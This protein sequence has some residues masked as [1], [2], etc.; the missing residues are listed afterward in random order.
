MKAWFSAGAITLLTFAPSVLSAWYPRSD[1]IIGPDFY[2]AFNFE[3][4]PDPTSGRV[5][6]LLGALVFYGAH[7]FL[8]NYVD[9]ATAQLR[10]LTFASSDTFILR[11]DHTTTLNASGPGRDS[12]RIRSNKAYTTHVAVSV[13]RSV[14]LPSYQ[15]D[16]VSRFDIRHMPQGCG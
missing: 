5:Y 2:N 13:F 16:C 6:T 7:L 11:A 9:Q 3:A 4:I 1:L 8:R 15:Y 10:N 12:V 14:S